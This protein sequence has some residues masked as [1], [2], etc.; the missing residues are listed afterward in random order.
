M[1]IRCSYFFT[2]ENPLSAPLI[3]RC[4]YPWEILPLLHDYLMGLIASLAEKGYTEIEE[5]VFVHDTA[6]VAPGAFIKGPCVIGPG[7]EI[8]HGA[9]IRGNALI[10]EGSVV[11]NSSELKNSLLIQHVQLPHYNYAGDSIFGTGSHMGAGSITSNVK[12]DHSPVCLHLSQSNIET[13]LKKFGAIVG[14]HSEVGCN[15]VLNPGTLLGPCSRIYPLT[16]ARGFI[17]DHHILKNTG[18]LCQIHSDEE[19]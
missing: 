8:R 3:R 10:G 18:E 14:D 6:E 1:D 5:H 4:Q 11:G 15:A 9:F 12:G 13:G 16:M 2:E 7:A 17:P 19:N